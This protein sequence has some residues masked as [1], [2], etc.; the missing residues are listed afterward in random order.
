MKIRC[1][2]ELHMQVNSKKLFCNCDSKVLI[3]EKSDYVIKRKLRAVKGETEKF[4]IAA[5]K[6]EEKNKMIN[7]NC[8]NENVCLVELDEEPP[9]E[10]NEKA[11][12]VG[13][14]IALLLNM[15]PVDEF[16]VMRKLIIDGSSVSG[17][18]RTGL[19]ATTGFIQ[20]SKGKVRIASLC[21]EEDSAK[22][23]DDNTFSLDRL[24]IPLIEIATEP[25]IVDANHAREVAEKIGNLCKFTG[26][27]IR[28]IGTIRQ[29]VNVSIPRGERV[30]IKGVQDLRMMNKFVELEAVRQENLLIIKEGLRHKRFKLDKPVNLTNIFKNT[31]C[32]FLKDS[33]IF[34]MNITKLNG[35]LGFKVQENKSFGK[36]IAEHVN[37]ATGLKGLLHRDELPNYG[38]TQKE[39]DSIVKKLGCKKE[40]NFIIIS[41]NEKLINKVHEII[42]ERLNQARIGV[43]KEVRAPNHANA[44]TSFLR[45]LPGGARMY[46]ETDV[47]VIRIKQEMISEIITNLSNT[48]EQEYESLK[49]MGLNGEL[50][51]QLLNS[52]KLDLFKEITDKTNV[53][54]NLTAS[55]I[56]ENEVNKI[57]LNKLI[58]IFNRLENGLICKE[59]VPE[60]IEKIINKKDFDELLKK[61]KT[62]SSKELMKEVNKTLIK[63][64]SKL[65]HPSTFGILM[66][67][68][69]KDL[70]GK[71]DAGLISKVLKKEIEKLR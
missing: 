53:D 68:L 36:D 46:P 57:D 54:N 15:K 9:H 56:L 45:P 64:K 71:A 5:K 33:T 29:D 10:I 13:L 24:G 41:C 23:V 25:D 60:I 21:L 58:I 1:G 59:A 4:D 37:Q 39:V 32:N 30:E 17:F 66:K 47:P 27:L 11:L 62:L 61:Y 16:H 69:M 12:R 18:Q 3:D 52:D 35:L 8:Y 49:S 22:R 2:L 34:G 26:K 70:R 28:G 40:D 38:I 48:P 63:N 50:A 44:T 65:S 7:Y 20:T 42:L 55:L 19:L 43:P 67:E 6:E 31:N 14:E 51:N